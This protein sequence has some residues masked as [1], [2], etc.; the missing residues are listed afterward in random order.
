V[1]DSAPTAH[2]DQ[3][4]KLK[5][6]LASHVFCTEQTQRGETWYVLKNEISG[7]HAR[8]NA[9]SY[10]IVARLD[11]RRSLENI[12]S[13]VKSLEMHVINE[14]V[15]VQL[16]VKLQRIGALV[17]CDFVDSDRLREEQ[18]QSARSSR[19][20]QWLNPLAVRINLYDPDAFLT[21]VTPRMAFL[22]SSATVWVWSLVL[23]VASISLLVNFS[24]ITQEFVTRTMRLQTLWWFALLFPAM[25]LLHEFSHALCVKYWGGQVRHV[26]LSLLLLIPVPYIDASDVYVTHTRRQRLILTAAGMAVELFVASVALLLWFWIEPG[27]IRDALFTV[28]II[29]GLT[30]VLFNANPLLK[31][32]GYYLLQDALDI[33]NLSARASVWLSYTFKRKVLGIQSMAEPKVSAQESKWLTLYGVAVIIYKPILTL[34]IVIFLWRAYPLLGVLLTLFA[35]VNQWLLPAGK[36]LHWM[37]T[38]NELQ[39]QRSRALGLVF[40]MVCVVTTVLLIPMPSTTRAQGVVAASD[41]GE[42]FSESGGVIT[43]IHVQPG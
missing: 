1:H 34:M 18:W 27:Y 5:P 15:L 40:C 19:L 32:D 21:Q 17:G 4:A 14:M 33:P 9:A 36:G 43:Q 3:L 38:S 37:F 42:V 30:T 7:E 41:Q 26:G 39:E 31:F 28:F 2:W 23:F 6:S 10:A 12:V 24:S 11:G 35:V 8:M 29:G 13:E 25:K 22:F 16:M 20:K